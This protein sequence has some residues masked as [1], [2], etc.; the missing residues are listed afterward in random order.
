MIKN[1]K[2]EITRDLK[3]NVK[4]FQILSSLRIPDPMAATSENSYVN[5]MFRVQDI[6]NLKAEMRRQFL[7]PLTPIQALLNELNDKDWVYQFETNIN[8]HFT[9]LFIIRNS[10]QNLWLKN[11][12]VLIMNSTYKTN[13]Y[14]MPLLV[15]SGQTALNINFYVAFCFMAQEKMIDYQ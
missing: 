13:R 5:F 3:V 4:L 10:S 8:D 2:S 7:G 6:Y 12:E 15:I 9:H 11:H 14:K 1:V